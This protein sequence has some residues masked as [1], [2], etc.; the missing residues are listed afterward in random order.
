VSKFIRY[1]RIFTLRW[2]TAHGSGGQSQTV[3]PP[4]VWNEP[5]PKQCGF[6]SKFERARRHGTP[7]QKNIDRHVVDDSDRVDRILGGFRDMGTGPRILL[8]V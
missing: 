3:T 1:H 7:G 5:V 6:D 2:L 4:K 8:G